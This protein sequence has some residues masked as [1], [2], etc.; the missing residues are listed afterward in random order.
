[1]NVQNRNWLGR[2]SDGIGKLDNQQAGGQ[3]NDSTFNPLSWGVLF[4]SLWLSLKTVDSMVPLGHFQRGLANVAI[5]VSIVIL[6]LIPLT[7]WL[8]DKLQTMLRNAN[9]LPIIYVITVSVYA[10]GV[11]TV[12][13][14]LKGLDITLAITIGFLW[15]VVYGIGMHPVLTG[16]LNKV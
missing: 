10:F 7:T 13:P 4:F 6:F 1:M 8:R 9:A 11:L 16:E 3:T 14:S 12:I 2:L 5:V 15:L